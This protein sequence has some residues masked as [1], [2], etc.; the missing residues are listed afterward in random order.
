ML[1]LIYPIPRASISIIR[2]M[3]PTSSNSFFSKML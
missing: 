2:G 1:A 3:L